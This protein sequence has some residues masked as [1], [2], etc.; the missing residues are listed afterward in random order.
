MMG[1]FKDVEMFG[2][3]FFKNMVEAVYDYTISDRGALTGYLVKKSNMVVSSDPTSVY[4]FNKTSTFDR[5]PSTGD[6][7]VEE[8]SLKI[9]FSDNDILKYPYYIYRI[10]NKIYLEINLR[11]FLIKKYIS[12]EPPSEDHPSGRVVMTKPDASRLLL[13]NIISEALSREI[14][15]EK[16]TNSTK[17]SVEDVFSSMEVTHSTLAPKLYQL[18]VDGSLAGIPEISQ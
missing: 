1:M 2:N 15:K 8:P 6:M 17:L 18:I 16:Y 13:V 4:S 12:M 10:D 9:R 14:V 3:M 11:D 5:T 7:S